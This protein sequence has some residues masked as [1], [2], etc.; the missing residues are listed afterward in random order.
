MANMK[1]ENV[2]KSV[3]F[4]IETNSSEFPTYRRGENGGWENLM[5]ES[6]E[7]CYMNEDE[8]EK[9]YQEWLAYGP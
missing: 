9:M 4:I 5:G 6:W 3:S 7:P 8:L 1:I 2:T